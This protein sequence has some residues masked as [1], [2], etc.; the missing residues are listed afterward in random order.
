[1]GSGGGRGRGGEGVE[2]KAG[3]G[4]ALQMELDRPVRA[5]YSANSWLQPVDLVAVSLSICTEYRVSCAQSTIS[6][7]WS[8][9]LD[10]RIPHGILKSGRSQKWR[11]YMGISLQVTSFLFRK[12]AKLSW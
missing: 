12:K 8:K 4:M 3:G 10:L 7:H 1:M 11:M 5:K 6:F 9:Y 2:G